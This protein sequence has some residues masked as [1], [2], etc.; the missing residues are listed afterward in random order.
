MRP[1]TAKA[2]AKAIARREDGARLL[3]PFVFLAALTALALSGCNTM[4]G[5]GEDISS[6]GQALDQT[7]ERTQDKLS[8]DEG[9]PRDGYQAGRY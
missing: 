8:G 1:T 9:A 2:K 7:S 6:A 4:S 5:V 3:L